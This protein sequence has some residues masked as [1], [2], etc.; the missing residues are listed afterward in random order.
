MMYTYQQDLEKKPVSGNRSPLL[1][2]LLKND[3][4]KQNI[5]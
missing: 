4:S 1:C 5:N 2:S 3:I